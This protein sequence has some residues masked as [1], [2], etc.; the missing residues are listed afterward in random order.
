MGKKIPVAI[1][2][3]YC[4]MPIPDTINFLEKYGVRAFRFKG[5]ASVD[6]DRVHAAIEKA[7]AEETL[8]HAIRAEA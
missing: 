7:A 1:A 5:R 3:K 6:E 2:A 8:L 4:G